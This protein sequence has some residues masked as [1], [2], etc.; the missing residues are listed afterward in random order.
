MPASA[1]PIV[2][3]GFSPHINRLYILRPGLHSSLLRRRPKQPD[4]FSCGPPAPTDSVLADLA[5]QCRADESL[6]LH[7]G[8]VFDD[9]TLEEEDFLVP[10]GQSV[11]GLS[12]LGFTTSTPVRGARAAPVS[13]LGE[14]SRIYFEPR[15]REMR[16]RRIGATQDRLAFEH[17]SRVASSPSYRSNARACKSIPRASRRSDTIHD[18]TIGNVDTVAA[19]VAGRRVVLDGVVGYKRV[20]LCVQAV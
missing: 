9:M 5:T 16:V 15:R 20:C 2:V 13:P 4:V 12:R 18:E 8:P 6:L 17:C 3:Y 11:A 1:D 14:P 10:F 7:T 19:R